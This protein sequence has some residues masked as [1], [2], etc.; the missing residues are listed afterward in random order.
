MPLLKP[1]G[2]V[3]GILGAMPEENLEIVRRSYRV[4]NEGGFDAVMAGDMFAPEIVLD[5]SPAG[6]PGLGTY[7]GYDGVKAFFD[8]WFGAFPFDEWEIELEELVDRGD[9]V[10]ALCRQ[11]GR[12][13]GSGASVELEFGQ[14]FELHDGKFTRIEIHLDRAQAASSA[15]GSGALGGQHASCPAHR[16]H[17]LGLPGGRQDRR[18]AVL[19]DAR[20]GAALRRGRRVGVRAA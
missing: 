8:D 2:P 10:V 16:R 9:R 13:A 20:R 11:R 6:I 5:V 4:F 19:H 7:D 12:G 17:L 14:V 18:G 15:A 3:R 1:S